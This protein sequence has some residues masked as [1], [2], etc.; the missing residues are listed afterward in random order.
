MI[1]NEERK[2]NYLSSKKNRAKII[3]LSS[4]QQS[5]EIRSIMKNEEENKNSNKNININIIDI[6]DNKV[7]V[8]FEN[9][10]NN[11]DI[12]DIKEKEKEKENKISNSRKNL[13]KISIRSSLRKLSL[14]ANKPEF[15]DI[16]DDE[17]E[18][19]LNFRQ[20][21]KIFFET[22]N[23]L[24]YIQLITA[25]LSI[26]TSI[27]YIVCT[28]I[29]ILFKSLNYIDFFACTLF[30]IEHVI[31]ILLS[32]HFIEYILSIE[33]LLSF[34]IEIPPFFS[35]LCD[36]FHL[37]GWYRFINI[38]RV[39][40]LIKGYK[41][42]E[43]LQGGE[44]SVNF[45]IFNIIGILFEII[46]IWAGIIQMLDLSIV[47]N[48][49]KI[50]FEVFNR[51]NLLL[52]THFH[53]YIYFIIVSLTT[54]GYG[55]IIPLSILGKFMII[56]L[57]IVIFVV[58][59]EQTSELINLS[60]AQTIYERKKYLSSPN[61]SFVILLGDIE[62]ETL[63]NFS[64]EYF[65][66]NQGNPFK[67]IVIL[68]NK[69]PEKNLELF[70][71][72]EDNIK[73]IT[74]LQGDPMNDNDL[75][76]C[77]L[78]HAKSCIIFTNKN[79]IDPHSSDHQSLLL[80]VFIK[81]FYYHSSME[82]YFDENKLTDLSNN[83]K[84]FSVNIKKANNILKNNRFR[85]FL[86][87]NK[88]ENCNHYFNTLQS[89]YKKNMLNDKLIVIESLKMN[90]LSKSCMTP[91]IISLISN[92]ISSNSF[93]Y[94]FFRNESEW[95][96]EYSEGQQYEIFK[97]YIEG[98]LLNYS[99]QK[100]AMEVYNKY[101]CLLIALEINY[102]GTSIF[103]LN[104]VSN[105]TINEIITSSFGLVNR[106]NREKTNI[107]ILDIDEASL[108]FLE[109]G[110]PNDLDSEYFS[111]YNND[112]KDEIER[113]KIK[114]FIF[115]ICDN[116]ET[117]N[118]IIKMDKIKN[119]RKKTR[120]ITNNNI[121][122]ALPLNIF[123]TKKTKKTTKTFKSEFY[124]N[125]VSYYYSE[126]ESEEENNDKIKYLLNSINEGESFFDHDELNKK[127][128]I[129]N[130]N[131]KN[132]LFSNEIMKIGI[133]DRSDIKHHVI[134]CG[135]HNEIMHLIL[136]LRLKYIPEQ[137][138]KWIVILCNHIP[139]E[140]HD[141]LS[142]FQKIIFI[143][144]DALNPD[145]LY[146]A[147]IKTADIAII[148]NSSFF[149]NNF[150]DNH[151]EIIGKD[152][153]ELA[154]NSSNNVK[155]KNNNILDGDAKT[156]FIYKSIKKIN[157][158]IQIITE[159]LKTNNI[160]F[161]HTSKELKK[162]Y[163]YSKLSKIYI[164]KSDYNHKVINNQNDNDIQNQNFEYTP[165]YAAGEVFLPSLIDKITGQ[166]YHKEYLY[167]ILN[168]L[169]TG[170]KGEEKFTN[171]KIKQLFNNLTNSN[172]FLIPTES[173]NESFGDMFLRLLTKNKMISI[174]LY[175]KNIN[176]NFYY[177]YTNP[178][179]TTLIRDTDL[180]F[181][182]ASTENILNL[183]E[184]HLFNPESSLKENNNKRLSV[185]NSENIINTNEKGKLSLKDSQDNNNQKQI[186]NINNNK[187]RRISI[188][189]DN[190]NFGA[191]NKNKDEKDI[192]IKKGK[193][194]EIDNLQN[195]LNKGM[196]KLRDIKNK[197]NDMP[198]YINNCINEGINE[199]FCVYLNKKVNS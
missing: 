182:L 86:Q 161:L 5:S 15:A 12:Y 102:K 64:K 125:P 23:R 80:S 176:D 75:L 119:K 88:I 57:V 163:K 140:I 69:M 55:E 188:L 158:S 137:L 100:L 135:M 56:F 174:A 21:I 39:F 13:K 191:K 164:E 36:N 193:Y 17:R 81:K 109:D 45:Q 117:K 149:D 169:L 190:I 93:D 123:K 29:N 110:K 40:R 108:S 195:I 165:V 122:E 6:I 66:K 194:T 186:D 118:E 50:T 133:N 131:D 156:L 151:H 142:K 171:Q 121:L 35:L 4:S 79:C 127:Y 84:D 198:R 89:T 111:N 91:G 48:D 124:D 52:R 167:N 20:R 87:L 16:L 9:N 148:L 170:E 101:H 197:T 160:E 72:K 31:N 63:K 41:I 175:R 25:I 143:Q 162:L 138:L 150:H 18:D 32:H 184:K 141:T 10:K 94:D 157:N 107:E 192:K 83:N 49:L 14:L 62:L 181:V 38:T 27:Y 146:K 96:K 78:L 95:L 173:R 152:E 76:R 1:Q 106:E 177:V 104:P 120:E 24:F 22:H 116:K 166:M 187:K 132:E 155:K 54:V 147:N 82:N 34:L 85:I 179:K 139:Q 44:K 99:F 183:I 47:E 168:L 115:L 112:K 199:E 114:V 58:V 2:N 65:N 68:M 185:E 60:N 8:Y 136:P 97:L 33:S 53:H 105:L 67:H 154:G 51:K 37:D 70:L 28:Y 7:D 159:L 42:L 11:I 196:S 178:R 144:G 128:Y 90:L 3:K 30:L 46:V 189:N 130:E 113:K 61:I 19:A 180:V 145:Y 59:P 134:I 26:V 77:D 92:L 98:N 74:Y 103:K 43:L 129:S 71:N 126:T 73:Y 153:E 172:L